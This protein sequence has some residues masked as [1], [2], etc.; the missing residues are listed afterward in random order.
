MGIDAFAG[1]LSATL[2][3]PMM[4]ASTLFGADMVA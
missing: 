1:S 3:A 4:G 2:G